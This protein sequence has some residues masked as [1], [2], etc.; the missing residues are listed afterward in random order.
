MN[1]TTFVIALVLLVLSEGLHLRKLQG[2]DEAIGHTSENYTSFLN[3]VATHRFD[4]TSV[5]HNASEQMF[6]AFLNKTRSMMQGQPLMFANPSETDRVAVTVFPGGSDVETYSQIIRWNLRMLG[7]R[8]ALQIFYGK[9]EERS[10]LHRALGNNSRVIWT[11]IVLQG[12]RKESTTL[13]EYNWL[14]LTKYFWRQIQH[15]H[16]LIFEPDS[17]VIKGSGCVESFFQYDYVGAPWKAHY[18]L[19]S[20]GNGGFSLRRRSSAIAAV[21]SPDAKEW[22]GDSPDSYY[23]AQDFIMCQLLDSVHANI[24]PIKKEGGFSVESIDFESPCGFHKPWKY[25][26]REVLSRLLHQALHNLPRQ[27]TSSDGSK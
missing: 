27:H 2:G 20:C 19:C 13:N 23:R 4:E 21:S 22:L 1:G 3:G 14:L 24:A 7:S 11:P 12:K 5:E 10:T 6:A 8:W 15:E 17:L 25:L 9:E 16:I 26:K 18:G